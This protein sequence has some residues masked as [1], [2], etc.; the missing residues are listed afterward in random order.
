[1]KTSKGRT[2][3]MDESILIVE[4]R[5]RY[6]N[7]N[8]LRERQKTIEL[9]ENDQKLLSIPREKSR[10]VDT[11]CVRRAH[12]I[13]T[14]AGL[15]RTNDIAYKIIVGI[16]T[17]EVGAVHISSDVWNYLRSFCFEGHRTLLQVL[18]EQLEYKSTS[19][20]ED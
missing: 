20:A 17:H 13:L 2:Y 5:I 18:K 3:Y 1:M 8:A 10:Q 19:L 6:E 12:M 11:A 15:E 16:Y 4:R 7:T 14:A 9:N